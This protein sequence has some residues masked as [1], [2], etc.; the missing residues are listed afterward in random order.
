MANHFTHAIPKGTM[1]LLQ[2]QRQ[3]S[4]GSPKMAPRTS[5]P[6]KTD[7]KKTNNGTRTGDAVSDDSE[8]GDDE[9]DS[10][11]NEDDDDDGLEPDR[12]ALSGAPRTGNG[13][14][15]RLA[16]LSPADAEMLD[17][18]QAVAGAQQ[19]DDEYG[20]TNEISDG[21]DSIGDDD[22]NVLRS[23]EKDL[24]AEFERTERPRTATAVTNEINDLSL[25]SRR[26]S[27]QSEDGRTYEDLDLDFN[28]DPFRGLQSNDRLYQEMI[29]D[30]EGMLNSDLDF[31]RRD[32]LNE[33]SRESSAPS[34]VT[35]KRVRFNETASSRTSSMSSS[36]AD[37]RD[38]YPD[39]FDGNDDPLLRHQMLMNDTGTE[40]FQDNESVYDFEDEFERVAYEID[41]EESESDSDISDVSCIDSRIPV[42]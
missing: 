6:K 8:D 7:T 12:F 21:D 23:A 27:V 5:K 17:D 39:L 4:N 37:P 36:E 34:T 14:S 13:A 31:W 32:E 3:L 30:A 38:A 15:P 29:G 25:D 9:G 26:P 2:N 42:C 19:S 1:Q 28:E 10:S 18:G 33:Q 24:I 11:A 40:V 22:E 35:Q 16:G 20:A 41:E